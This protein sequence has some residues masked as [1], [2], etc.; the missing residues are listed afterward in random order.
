MLKKI[1]SWITG[2]KD[3]SDNAEKKQKKDKKDMTL[4]EKI[5]D[6]I[7]VFFSAYLIAFVIRLFLI[8]AYQIPSQSMVPNLMVQDILMV[9]KFSFGS[10]LP[11]AHWKLPAIFKPTRGDIIVFVS[12]EWKSPGWG[13]ELITLVS[14]SL[15]NLD[16]T[17]ENPKNLVKRLIGMP[18]DKIIMTNRQL[19]INNH[20]LVTDYITN[21]SQITYNHFNQTGINFYD[22]YAEN[23]SNRIRI[24]QFLHFDSAYYNPVPSMHLDLRK[25]F[26][27]IT[28]PVKDVPIDLAKANDYY[29]HL[30][31]MLI[32]RE[33]GK[34]V[35]QGADGN[36]Y[37]E[38]T[39]IDT[40]TPKENYYFGMGDNRDNSQDCRYFG[41][42][43]ETNIFGR[44]LFRYFPFFR[45][46]F[47]VD[48]N[49]Q[50]VKNV[51]FNK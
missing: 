42:I 33:T 31:Q 10:I 19:I 49:S 11:I 18:G 29:K 40:Y 4:Q 5:V 34:D 22:L 27:E 16:N 48:E 37:I 32:E 30:L 25:D 23:F 45:I 41:F 20:P 47:N 1:L 9:E 26:P 17:M 12:P 39:K 44:I 6:N 8:E 50:S 43:P 7:K 14:L 13:E 51:K 24:I 3:T 36:I 2:K 35:I 28:V 21:V 38:G 46:A 15:I